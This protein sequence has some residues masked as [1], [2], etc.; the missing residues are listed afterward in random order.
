MPLP[1]K[2]SP[3]P[4]LISSIELRFVSK[5]NKDLML[6]A[7]F[8]VFSDELPI[9]STSKIP[10]ELRVQ[11]QFKYAGD[12]SF[13]NDVYSLSFSDK[14]VVIE[15]I[16]EYPLWDSFF[17]FVK[18]QFSKLLKTNL[19]ETIERIG[20][21]YASVLD[22]TEE[23][24]KILTHIPRFNIENFEEDLILVR[25]DLKRNGKNLHLQ[26]V[27]NA[28]IERNKI[29]KNGTFID[30]DASYKGPIEPNERIFKEITELHS[31]QKDLFFELI[32][33]DYLNKL[34]PEY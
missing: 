34:N 17:S 8:P 4:L 13:S 19:M 22:H 26:I 5:S 25:T 31:L 20:V 18:N 12:Y 21:R 33:K 30:I 16:G 2:I 24:N 15:V 29:V 11:E 3:N 9:L 32:S 6:A 23:L 14:V 10:A 27:K 7:L 1:K 28:K